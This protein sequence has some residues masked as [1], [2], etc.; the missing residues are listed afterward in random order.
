[1][2]DLKKYEQEI[3]RYAANKDVSVAVA[4]SD[5]IYNLAMMRPQIEGFDPQLDFRDLGQQWNKLSSSMRNKQKA[6]ITAAPSRPM[7]T[8]KGE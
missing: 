8:L 3:R 7:K 4:T 2:F 5:F 1:M 6:S